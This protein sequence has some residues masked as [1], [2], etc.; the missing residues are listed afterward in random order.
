MSKR[1]NTYNS[2]FVRLDTLKPWPRNYKTHGERQL[3]VLGSSLRNLG[4]FK[5]V[6][7]WRDYI[8]AGH[9]LI[10]AA[11]H[12]GYDEVE[13]KRLP[14]GWTETQVEAVLVADNES[15]RLA[16]DDTEQLADLLESIRREDAALLDSVGWDSDELDELLAELGRIGEPTSE[17]ADTE[18]Q[19]DRAEE[20]RQ[21]WGVESGQLWAMGPHKIICGDCT[22]P[23]VV[24]RLMDGERADCVVTDPPYGVGIEYSDFDDTI[25]EVKR[26]IDG[27]F[28]IVLGMDCPIL[29]TPGIPAMWMYPKPNWVLG[30]IHP[31]STSSGPWGFIGL[32]PILAYGK[33]PYLSNGMGRQQ[34]HIVEV[35]DRSGESLHPVT[36][37]LSVWEW[38]VKRCSIAEHDIVYEPF[39][40]SGTSI[41][42]CHN[43]NR[44]CRAVE[45]SPAY[46]AVCL[47][48]YAD[49]TSIQP[50]LISE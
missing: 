14:D 43:L 40:G 12:D 41:I 39:A 37:P 18:P 30:W 29:I 45:I 32:N 42:A 20:L 7:V 15:S 3:S 19:T 33:D 31:A 10:E 2:E 5:N 38:V 23:A 13:V 34:G 16:D 28:P 24:D 46:V 1:P 49:H 47:Q 6:V 27:F 22:D 11:Q 17:G 44:I 21:E 35:A 36:K 4:Q 8:V 9:G 48:R 25:E 50:E 26:L